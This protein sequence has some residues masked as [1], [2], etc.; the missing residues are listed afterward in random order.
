MIYEATI[1]RSE[2][3][4]DG[5]NKNVSE[6]F[7]VENMELCAEVE[8]RVLEE[9]N[10]ECECTS[11]KQSSVREF[12]NAKDD[13]LCHIFLVKL[14]EAV[15]NENTGEEKTTNYM[16][17]LFENDIETA[18]KRVMEYIK[19]CMSDLRIVSIKKTKFIDLLNK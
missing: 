3:T 2:L 14:E 13:S 1:K 5:A 11:I 6:K 19:G 16:V 7:Y 4:A 9:F 12:I 18:T 10:G 8:A 17:A 15:L